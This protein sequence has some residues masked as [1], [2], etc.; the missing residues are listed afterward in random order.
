MRGYPDDI[1]NGNGQVTGVGLARYRDGLDGKRSATPGQVRGP[2]YH[3]TTA[4]PAAVEH[5]YG[6]DSVAAVSTFG[7][8]PASP[9][10]SARRCGVKSSGFL[11]LLR[12]DTL[13]LALPRRGRHAGR[14]RVGPATGCPLPHNGQLGT[15]P[16]SPTHRRCVRCLRADHRPSRCSLQHV[17]PSPIV[18]LRS[19]V[20]VLRKTTP[21][22][23]GSILRSMRAS[24]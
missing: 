10:P 4:T 7:S 24:T 11:W 17:Y 21:N 8:R 3:T 13:V 22:A 2:L 18:V 9:P 16:V 5:D 14:G 23:Q 15:R 1:V 19:S 20:S 6:P 12:G